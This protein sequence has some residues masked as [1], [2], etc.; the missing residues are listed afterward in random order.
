MHKGWKQKALPVVSALLNYDGRI[1]FSLS[2]LLHTAGKGEDH[3][4]NVMVVILD[5]AFLVSCF[6]EASFFKE[7]FY[8][9]SGP[10]V[11]LT[12]VIRYAIHNNLTTLALAFL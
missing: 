10:R 9:C 11:N 12:S 6:A 8:E 2:A 1:L 5:T 3:N 7:I 4:L